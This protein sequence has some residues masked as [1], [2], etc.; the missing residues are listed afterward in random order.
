MAYKCAVCGKKV[1]S[2]NKVSHSSRH[3]RRKWLPNLQSVRAII[4]GVTKRVKV[5]TSCIK[6]NKVTKAV[7]RNYKP[8]KA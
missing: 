3:T 7:K 8:A 4:D 5:C 6:S 2:G 1:V